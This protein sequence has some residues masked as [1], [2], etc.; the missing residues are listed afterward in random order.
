[1]FFMMTCNFIKKRLQLRCFPVSI[2]KFLRTASYVNTFSGCIWSYLLSYLR[3]DSLAHEILIAITK[4]ALRT[5]RNEFSSLN[6][7]E[8]LMGFE[9]QLWEFVITFILLF[10]QAMKEKIDPAKKYSIQERIGKGSFG[11]VYKA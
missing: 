8:S 11:E 7:A 5:S 6:S 1:M 2:T 9:P 3:R 10:C 4:M